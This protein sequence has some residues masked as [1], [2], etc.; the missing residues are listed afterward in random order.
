MTRRRRS[1][2]VGGLLVSIGVAIS[3]WLWSQRNV[4][5]ILPT[6]PSARHFAEDLYPN[7]AQDIESWFVDTLPRAISKEGARDIL[8]ASFSVDLT[9]GHPILIHRSSSMAGGC[10]TKV[11]LRFDHGYEGAHVDQ[12]WAFL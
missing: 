6:G 8:G 1:L 11:T 10:W 2:V 7:Y 3:A 12:H 5:F 9:S 4:D